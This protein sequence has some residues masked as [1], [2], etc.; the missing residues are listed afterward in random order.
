M[1]DETNVAE[2]AA[3]SAVRL[4]VSVDGGAEPTDS[5]GAMALWMR[6]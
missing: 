4:N 2:L 1:R 5:F 6:G 3:Y